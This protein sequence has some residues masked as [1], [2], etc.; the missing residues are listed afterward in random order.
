MRKFFTWL[1]VVAAVAFVAAAGGVA[2]VAHRGSALDAQAQAFAEV[3]V[4]A[5]AARW[6]PHELVIRADPTLLQTGTLEQLTAFFRTLAKLGPLTAGRECRG[7]ASVFAFSGQPT[8]TTA[9][10]KCSAHFRDGDAEI[11][12]DLIKHGDAWRI[13]GFHVKGSGPRPHDSRQDI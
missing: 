10:Y 8:R 1:G 6:D 5:V 2:Y 12:L 7:G 3:T 9:H 11:N 4:D 13:T